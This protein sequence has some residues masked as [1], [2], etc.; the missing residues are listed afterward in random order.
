MHLERLTELVAGFSDEKAQNIQILPH[1]SLYQRGN[2]SDFEAVIYEPL[3]CLILQGSKETN[4]GNQYANLSVGD[5]LLVTHDL[6]VVSRITQATAQMPY[7]A[8]ILSLNMK[9]VRSLYAQVA[10]GPEAGAHTRPLSCAPADPAWLAPLVRYMELADNPRDATVLGPS[11]VREIHYRLLL[12][13]IGLMLRSLLVA[14]SHGS[15]IGKAIQKL[16]AEFRHQVAVSDLAHVAGMSV[17]SFHKH[18]KSVTGVTPLQYQKD[19]KLIEARTLLVGHGATVSK[20]AY[21]VGYESPTHFS[22]DYKRKFGL[23]PSRD[24]L[25][26]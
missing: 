14:D 8:L 26:A 11:T 13:P 3:I 10:D 5:A 4:V 20:A 12:S 21:A 6:P 9:D 22:R 16:R 17:S 18:F 23:A 1:L 24:R 15:R 2:V 25:T 19:M 7:V